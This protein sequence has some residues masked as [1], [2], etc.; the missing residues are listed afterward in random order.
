MEEAARIDHTHTIEAAQRA[1]HHHPDYSLGTL[2]KV[3]PAA[4]AIAV[5]TA[6]AS[7][8]TLPT[9]AEGPAIHKDLSAE[10]HP[11]ARQ[12]PQPPKD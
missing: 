1:A 4:A 12:T 11:N 6:T 5:A 7:R 2:K 8:V 3:V 10:S 9:K